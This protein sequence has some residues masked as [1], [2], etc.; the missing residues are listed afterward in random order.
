MNVSV[1][2]SL[3]SLNISSLN[4]SGNCENVAL[5]YNVWYNDFLLQQPVE[6]NWTTTPNP[7][8]DG[9]GGLAFWL[10]G[11]SPE[12]IRF[13]RAMLPPGQSTKN[14]SDAEIA[15]WTNSTPFYE[16]FIDDLGNAWPRPDNIY[17]V[18]QTSL[19]PQIVLY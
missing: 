6:G 10:N 8:D 7:S 19:S 5:G 3:A 16:F 14:V 17:Q 15:T 2:T 1:P 12:F 4:F 13:W 18:L 9:P 11:T